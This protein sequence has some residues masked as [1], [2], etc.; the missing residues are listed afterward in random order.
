MC[1]LWGREWKS[2]SPVIPF[3]HN[4]NN[5]W[6]SKSTNLYLWPIVNRTKKV[7][8]LCHSKLK[9]AS[10]HHRALLNDCSCD[11]SNK[12]VALPPAAQLDSPALKMPRFEPWNL[13]FRKSSSLPIRL[14]K[15]TKKLWPV[16]FSKSNYIFVFEVTDWTRST[17]STC[18]MASKAMWEVDPETRS[19]VT[20]PFMTSAFPSRMTQ[21]RFLLTMC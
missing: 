8:S 4:C 3:I 19:K 13:L 20:P 10:K 1:S 11:T 5:F 17:C 18:S 21:L 6:P 7:L 14:H 12:I 15:I 9:I 16:S 2:Y